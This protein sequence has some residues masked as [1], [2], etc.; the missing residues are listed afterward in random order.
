MCQKVMKKGKEVIELNWE[1]NNPF[2]VAQDEQKNHD[3]QRKTFEF[4]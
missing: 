2:A 1:K 3:K 4:V